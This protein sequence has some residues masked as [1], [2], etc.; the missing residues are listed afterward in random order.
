MMVNL[1][2]I[3]Y[4]CPSI[5]ILTMKRLSIFAAQ[6][7]IGLSLMA[8]QAPRNWF[9]LDKDN[10]GVWG[11]STNKAYEKFNLINNKP[12][13]IVAVIDAGTDVDHEDLKSMLWVN[14]KEIA[15][16]QK[17]DDGNGYIDDVY[18]WN[19]I[20][21]ST[22]NVGED[23]YESTRLVVAL[24]KKTNRTAEEE[25]LYKR[26]LEL[27][28][29]SAKE[30]DE[31]LK[32]LNTILDAINNAAK[33]T[34]SKNPSLDQVN[35]I[36]A[37][38][39]EEKLGKQ[40]LSYVVQTGGLTESPIMSS[41]QEGLDQLN[42]MKNFNLNKNF[43]PRNKVGDNYQN[44]NERIYGN[45]RV[46]GPKAEHGTHVAGII[47]ADRTNEI[48]MQG[49]CQMAQIMTIRCVPDGDERDKDVA[50]AIRYA[51]DNGAKV[52][53]MSF[54]KKISPHVG[55]VQEAIAYAASKDVL[56]IHAAG[57]DAANLEKE[58]FF[59]QGYKESTKTN[60]DHWIE[61]GAMGAG[62]G[63]KRVASFS[64]YGKTHV[65]V[66]APGV[67]IYSCV[68]GSEYKNH[69]GTSMAA[70]MVAGVAALIR[71]NYPNLSAAQTKQIILMS[72]IP[73]TEKVV[74]PGSKKKTKLSKISRTGGI[75][76]AYTALELAEKVSKGEVKVN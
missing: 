9:N 19:F 62:E 26:A 74:I 72:A 35:A 30:N 24:E 20:G 59:P 57:N 73:C 51:A 12:K 76:N 40:L 13:V 4:N 8:Q 50:N 70:P 29:N 45:G 41:L 38:T 61:V 43:D 25:A 75:V 27:Y 58:V 17:D 23:T 2:N 66:F 22:E 49:V 36:K 32:Q 42:T 14:P 68:P 69:N 54:G 44:I 39:K 47:A 55:L 5:L 18:G 33:K 16:N 67:D 64:N 48:G 21:G 53:N 52:V 56:L 65:D 60:F 71:Q 6:L 10:D 34:G 46:N 11:M 7:A 3:K 31:Q 63:K 15:G 28:T 1:R 37:E